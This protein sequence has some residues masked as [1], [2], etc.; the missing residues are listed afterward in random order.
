MTKSFYWQCIWPI[1]VGFAIATITALF[2]H[3]QTLEAQT[4]IDRMMDTRNKLERNL[5]RLYERHSRYTSRIQEALLSQAPVR[6]R[7]TMRWAGNNY[8]T[9][10]EKEINTLNKLLATEFDQNHPPKIRSDLR[11]IEQAIS[12]IQESSLVIVSILEKLDRELDILE[13]LDLVESNITQLDDELAPLLFKAHRTL[14]DNVQIALSTIRTSQTLL[15][16]KLRPSET[17]FP[18][19]WLPFFLWIPL[20]LWLFRRPINRIE[21][22]GTRN[23]TSPQETRLETQIAR[24]LHQLQKDLQY[25]EKLVSDR[26]TEAQR[27][28]QSTRRAEHELALLRIYNENLA[29]NLRSAVVVS[30]MTGGVTSVNRAARRLFQTQ[31]NATESIESIESF[32][33]YQALLTRLPDLPEQLE[34][35]AQDNTLL[36]TDTLPVELNQIDHL[37]DLTVVPYQDE[38][39]VTRGY[40]WVSDDV[41][42]SVQMKNQLLASEHLATVGRM[43]AQVAH[44]IRNPLSAIGLNAELLEEEFAQ[45]LPKPQGDE[46]VSLLRAIEHEI[47]RLTQITEGYLTLTKTPQPQYQDCDLNASVTSLMTMLRAGFIA[48]SIDLSLNLAAP[49]P[50][51]WAD[52]GQIRQAL[53]N[54]IRNAEEAM[55]DGGSLSIATSQSGDYCQISI[56]DSGGGIPDVVQPRIF[57]P[58]YTTKSEGTGLGLSLTQQIIIDH[59]GVI[60][61]ADS[62]SAGTTITIR[63]PSSGASEG[64]SSP[65][66]SV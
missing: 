7:T 3:H 41:T 28:N 35:I 8:P 33:F 46:A 59:G 37:L 44:E 43:S 64:P 2:V 23:S 5:A 1:L 49:P 45:F 26:D 48:K 50:I 32:S 66:P 38:S 39:G 62:S 20:A 6:I 40:L 25:A 14:Q 52:P 55:T 47:E 29:N 65:E 21:S 42:A 4:T 18:L 16:N 27:S 54:T 60:N 34:T 56:S 11:R 12:R 36:Q 10:L 61:V 22:L 31:E 63:I 53:I 24:R 13:K 58:F 51:A 30:N 19:A 57:E 9:D 17:A 15:F